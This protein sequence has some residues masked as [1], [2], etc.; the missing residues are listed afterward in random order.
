MSDFDTLRKEAANSGQYMKV[1]TKDVIDLI[2][3]IE[4]WLDGD[5]KEKGRIADLEKQ[6]AAEK[7]LSEAISRDCNA[8][9]LERNALRDELA[10]RLAKAQAE[11]DEAT[12]LALERAAKVC[13]DEMVDGSVSHEDQFY[14]LGITHAMDSIRSLKSKPLEPDLT[15]NTD[16]A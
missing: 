8:T 5:K 6:L 9:A 2:D 11:R 12:D 14:N 16:K 4:P 15:T 7:K 13:E 10:S 1:P 3:I